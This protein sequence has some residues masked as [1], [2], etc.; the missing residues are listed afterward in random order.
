MAVDVPVVI[1]V[2]SPRLPGGSAARDGAEG[3]A[4]REIGVDENFFSQLPRSPCPV[5]QKIGDSVRAVR[6]LNQKVEAIAVLM[7]KYR[8]PLYAISQI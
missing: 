4:G 2:V 3:R 6:G 5:P 1:I 7:K 8:H